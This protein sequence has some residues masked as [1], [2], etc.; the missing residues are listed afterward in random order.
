MTETLSPLHQLFQDQWDAWVRFDPLFATYVG[1]K[2]YND[3]LPEA[4]DDS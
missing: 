3:C 4:T 2:R 1:D